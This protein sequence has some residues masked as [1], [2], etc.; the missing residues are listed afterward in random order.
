MNFYYTFHIKT[1]FFDKLQ[2]YSASR[3]RLA[4]RIA[5]ACADTLL[6]NN[7]NNNSFAHH[8]LEKA[9]NEVVGDRKYMQL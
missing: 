9:S 3:I 2:N 1:N 4:V 6:H 8:V 7:N 5:R